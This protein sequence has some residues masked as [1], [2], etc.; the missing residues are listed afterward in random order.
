MKKNYKDDFLERVRAS[1]EA[2]KESDWDMLLLVLIIIAGWW[3]V[4]I[5]M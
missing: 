2:Q 1:R 5:F 4:G 3:E